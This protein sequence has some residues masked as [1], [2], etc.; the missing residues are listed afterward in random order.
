MQLSLSEG[1]WQLFVTFNDIS[2]IERDKVDFNFNTVRQGKVQVHAAEG[3]SLSLTIQAARRKWGCDMQNR[4]GHIISM[5]YYNN[6]ADQ[7]L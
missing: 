5:M 1:A 4:I 3:Y 7:R 6:L 2:S